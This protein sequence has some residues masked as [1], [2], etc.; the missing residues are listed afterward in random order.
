MTR[1]GTLWL[2]WPSVGGPSPDVRVQ[3][4]P[5]DAQPFYRHA[6]WMK[7]GEGWPW[8][9]ASGIKGVR[10][11]R[12]E[13]MARATN[14]PSANFSARWT[15]FVQTDASETNTFHVRSD[16]TVRVWVE[17][18]PI[19][20]TGRLKPT[21]TPREATGK[22]FLEAGRKYPLVVEYSH[23]AGTNAALVELNWS[24]PSRPR[25]TISSSCL[26][27]P[28]GKRNGVAGVY[29]TRAT[30]GGPGLVQVDP[31]INF[32]WDRELP[33]LLR[34]PRESVASGERAYTVRL[35]FAEPEDIRAGQRVFDVKLQGREV[36]PSLD[37][38]KQAGGAMRGIVREFRGVKAA[39]ALEIEFV[40]RSAKPPLV[41]GVELIAEQP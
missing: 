27:T 22:L 10:S 31:Q 11:V 4:A 33:P 19:L 20:D 16:G 36:L 26:F 39:E 9:F 34:K 6:L 35:V 17:G 38:V 12:I 32:N 23:A 15:G 25:A 24:S 14:A 13:T 29:F 37:I 28:D 2:D 41:C 7:G 18:F 40:P 5:A 1:D 8:V 30:P 21:A 3:V